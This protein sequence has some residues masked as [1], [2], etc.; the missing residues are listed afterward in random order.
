MEEKAASPISHQ[1]LPLYSGCSKT[2]WLLS[3]LADLEEKM[4]E[5]AFTNS[6]EDENGDTFAQR[7]ESYYHKRPQL[8]ALLHHLYNAHLNLAHRY[9]ATRHCRT[10]S[11][12][13]ISTV[14]TS[15]GSSSSGNEEDSDAE[16]SLSYQQPQPTANQDCDAVVA[17][18]VIKWVDCEILE[19]ELGAAERR[20][21]ESWRKTEVQRSLVE[22]LE[23]ERE[24]LAK[25]NGRLGRR[26]RALEEENRRLGAETGW[27][28]RKAAE[29]YAKCVVGMGEEH[30]MWVLGR[31]IEDLQG[32]I[33]G[34]ERRNQEYY[35]MLQSSHWK[36]EKGSGGGGGGK[37]GRRWWGRLK[38]MDLFQCMP[39]T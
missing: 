34:L 32:Q 18:L 8:L 38:S 24:I 20:W 5:V 27:T 13:H 16:S 29:V 17:E 19:Q 22:V 9:C 28:R 10:L 4:K 31:K 30:R 1:S 15:D 23:A 12:P 39:H 14:T 21:G 33:D 35:E 26:V 2:S 37:K 36:K 11:F 7:A 3:T 25:E 6:E